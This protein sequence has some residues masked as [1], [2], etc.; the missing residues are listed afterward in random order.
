MININDLFK[1]WKVDSEYLD[2]ITYKDLY[3]YIISFS[4]HGHNVLV[5]FFRYCV[6]LFS[7]D[8]DKI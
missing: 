5:R 2:L 8:L 3:R 6:F 4:Y 1:E 7:N